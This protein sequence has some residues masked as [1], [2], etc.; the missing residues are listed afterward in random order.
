MMKNVL[1]LGVGWLVCA[2]PAGAQEDQPWWTTQGDPVLQA[3]IE[4]GL[5]GNGDVQ[6]AWYRAEQADA[7]AAAALAPIL[8]S[9]SFDVGANLAPYDSLGFGFGGLTEFEWP[10]FPDIPGVEWPEMD[11]D[12]GEDPSVYWTGQA[13][14]SARVPLNLWGSSIPTP[15]AGR[16]AAQAAEGDAQAQTLA[17][18]SAVAG[19]YYDVLAA[20]QQLALL[21][22]QLEANRALLEITQLRFETSEAT[23]LDVLQQRQQVAAG[24]SRVPQAR[25]LEQIASQRLAT[26]IGRSPDAGLELGRDTLPVLAELPVAPTPADLTPDRPDLRAASSRLDA[27]RLRKDA[28]GRDFLP[29]LALTGQAGVQWNHI[30][31]FDS[32]PTWGAG[33]SLS[34]PLFEGT[35]RWQG[36]REARAG[37][38]AAQRQLDQLQL[39][40]RQQVDAA[41]VSETEQRAELDAL[42]VQLDAAATAHDEARARYAAGLTS[43]ITVL[44]AMTTRQQ[45]EIG[46]L[47]A[48]R[49]LF[50]TRI[51]LHEA[52]GG[53]WTTDLSRN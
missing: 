34:L 5:G 49:N 50:D 3:L 9:A 18:A 51:Q 26:L 45:V 31:E 28:T 13:M 14:V 8:P 22:G 41:L 17:L 23:G 4:E 48:E 47:Q 44:V 12:T 53:P 7:R 46:V 20:R 1:L 33:A 10:E 19:A 35:R 25:R 21:E 37:E 42:R 32:L 11:Q 36:V 24:E 39:Q 43:Y 38:D 2:A 30:E 40:A 6:A 52:L 27:A 16:Y 29:T 15:R